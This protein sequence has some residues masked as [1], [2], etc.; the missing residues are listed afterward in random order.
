MSAMN[1]NLNS[2]SSPFRPS[3]CFTPEEIRALTARSDLAGIALTAGLWAS[4]AACFALMALIPHPVTF[5]LGVILLGGR[6]H[7]LAVL[8]HEAAHRTLCRSA[9]LNTVLG[10]WLGARLIWQDVPRYREHHLRHHANTGTADD[11]DLSL[12]RP[13]PCSRRSLLK[14]ILRDLSGQTALRRMAAQ[15]LMDIGVFRYTVAAKVERLPR[16]GRRWWNYAAQGVR[17]MAGFVLTNLVLFGVLWAFGIGWTY[18][19]W[20]LAYLTTFSLYIR[21]RSIA[22]HA[23]LQS[24]PNVLHNT[25]TAQAGWLAK[26]MLAPFNVAYHQEHHL[27]AAVP[28]YRLPRLHRLLRERGVVGAPSGYAGVWRAA[29]RVSS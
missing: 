29:T 7:A 1:P 5:L 4:I 8:G 11:P 23:V 25:R 3:T 15:L 2:S 18:A 19:A 14:R 26:I 10:D 22:E 6:Q 27:M 12:T 24:G 16:G 17:N 28:C 13:Y 20:A 9:G 21:L